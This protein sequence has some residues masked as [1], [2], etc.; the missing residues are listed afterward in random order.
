MNLFLSH[1]M[2]NRGIYIHQ[3][4]FYQYRYAM[5]IH[6]LYFLEMVQYNKMKTNSSLQTVQLNPYF[7]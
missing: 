3:F 2:P 4:L 6:N 7:L 5:R 1:L